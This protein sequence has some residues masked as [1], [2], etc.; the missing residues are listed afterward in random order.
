MGPKWAE[1][2]L[3]DQLYDFIMSIA[4]NAKPTLIWDV[5]YQCKLRNGTTIFLN[6]YCWRL[7]SSFYHCCRPIYLFWRYTV[8][9]G[10]SALHFGSIA[11]DHR[12][13]CWKKMEKHKVKSE[14]N[15][16]IGDQQ[17]RLKCERAYFKCLTCSEINSWRCRF[18]VFLKPIDWMQSLGIN[19]QA[20]FPIICW[21]LICRIHSGLTDQF[22]DGW[23]ALQSS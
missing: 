6:C 8:R 4:A 12:F 1:I 9:H 23:I 13:A 16:G 5:L 3:F 20:I 17:V 11:V 15:E 18:I 14:F 22:S 19:W 7:L 21:Q 2:I 10:N